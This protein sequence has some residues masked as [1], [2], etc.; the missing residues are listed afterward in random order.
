MT[1]GYG[2]EWVRS[3]FRSYWRLFRDRP[4]VLTPGRYVFAPKNTPCCPFPTF[5]G[6]RDWT[7]DERDPWPELGEWEGART[8]DSGRYDDVWP[9]AI[10]VG[11]RECI[12]NG[13][14]TYPP[15]TDRDFIAGFDRLCFRKP[16][17]EARAVATVDIADR[18]TQLTFARIQTELYLDAAQAGADLLSFLG[19]P[20]VVSSVANDAGSNVPGSLIATAPGKLLVIVSGT[21]TPQQLA[22]QFAYGVAPINVGQFSTHLI[23]WAASW[24]IHARAI[25]AGAN[26]NDEVILIGHSYGAAVATILAARYRLGDPARSIR[27]LTY[28]C[29]QTMDARGRE[30]LQSVPQIHVANRGDPVPELPPHRLDLIPF[31]SI[32]PAPILAVWPEL[33][34][35]DHQ[36]LLSADGTLVED[37]ASSLTWGQT[38]NYILEIVNTGTISP[39]LAHAIATYRDR[40]IGRAHV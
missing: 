39:V 9:S 23:H 11:T 33:G 30:I 7:S 25:A 19:P 6:S 35:L 10:I 15:S 18:G 37:N 36:W 21:T 8:W 16:E 17:P 29:P 1:C 5:L 26:N 22:L 34:P 27:L 4:E 40:Q 3:S 32:V 12:E 28:A 14:T 38:W 20:Y 2:V 24:I 13:E 31:L